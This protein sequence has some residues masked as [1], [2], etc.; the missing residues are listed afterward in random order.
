MTAKQAAAYLQIDLATA[1]TL[2]SSTIGLPVH[3]IGTRPKA[4]RRFYRD[5]LDAW[6]KSRCT[7][8]TPANEQGPAA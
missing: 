4:A 7:W 3:R 6:V 2:G 1:T 5:E 8:T